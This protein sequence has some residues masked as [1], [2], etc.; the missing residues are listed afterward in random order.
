VNE[1]VA[2]GRRALRR[3]K[4]RRRVTGVLCAAAVTTALLA[5]GNQVEWW[6]GGETEV[7]TGGEEASVSATSAGAER[8][9]ASSAA[10][11]S[12]SDESMSTYSSQTIELVTNRQVWSGI[13]CTLAPLGW[14]PEPAVT[15]ERVVLTPPSARTSEAA[16]KLELRAAPQAQTLQAVRVTEDAGRLYHLG[17]LAGRQAGQVMHG[18]KWLMVQLPVG[19]KVWSDDLLRRFLASCTVN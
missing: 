18:D 1:D 10:T 3:I 17:T 13:G 11:P 16:A 7:A 15:A 9:G 19:S 14:T 4:A 8:F 5:V 2:R 6:D 12:R